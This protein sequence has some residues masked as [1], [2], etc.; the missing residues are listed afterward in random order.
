MKSVLSVTNNVMFMTSNKF[1]DENKAFASTNI[2][3]RL[4]FGFSEIRASRTFA[5]QI[6]YDF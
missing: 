1:T 5:D 2:F 3:V 6:L 4:A